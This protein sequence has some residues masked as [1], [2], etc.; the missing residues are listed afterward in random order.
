MRF[1]V[2]VKGREFEV[3]ESFWQVV[4]EVCAIK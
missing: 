1:A 3:L 4:R 2:A